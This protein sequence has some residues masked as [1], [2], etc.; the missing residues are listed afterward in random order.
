REALL[1]D[2]AVERVDLGAMHEQL[3]FA[4]GLMSQGATLGV[5]GDGRA[6]QPGLAV[7]DV[8]VGL[9]ELDA[10]VPRGL[11]LRAGQDE[12]GLDALDELVVAAR[13]AVLRDQLRSRR[14]G[15][16][17]SVRTAGP[18]AP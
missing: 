9:A 13:A 6:D 5:L 11:H 15:P 17:R 12:T 4:V 7:A 10:A 3:A 18:V 14:L 16:R 1:P 8:R 2:L